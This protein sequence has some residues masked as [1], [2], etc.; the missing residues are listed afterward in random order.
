MKI[1]PLAAIVI[2]GAITISSAS[3]LVLWY[4]Q[5]AVVTRSS[6]LINEALPIGNGQL[7]GLI[8]GGHGA[9]TDRVERGQPVDRRRKSQ[10][11]LQHDGRL[12]D[13][14]QTCSSI[15]PGM[16]TSTDYR[17]DLDI[18]DALAHVSYES[19]GVKFSREYFCSHADGVLV[20]RLTADKPGSYTGSIELNDSHGAT[21]C[22]GQKPTHG[23]RRTD[24]RIEIRGA[25][26]RACTTAARCKRTA[27]R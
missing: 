11:Q 26:D 15:C 9:R 6:P 1:I 12:S 24:Q 14:R 2:F 3:D 27:R 7:G 5:P 8:A 19:D 10:R 25:I 4:Q 18:G 22:R 17:R 23:R 13:A 16:K 20:V 21:T